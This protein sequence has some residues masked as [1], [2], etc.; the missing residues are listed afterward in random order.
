MSSHNTNSGITMSSLDGLNKQPSS[1]SNS[2][3]QQHQQAHQ[4]HSYQNSVLPLT[5]DRLN[6]YSNGHYVNNNNTNNNNSPEMQKLSQQMTY[7]SGV[8]AAATPL[9]V[10]PQSTTIQPPVMPMTPQSAHS[11]SFHQS[12]QPQISQSRKC[13]Q[14]PP[15]PAPHMDPN[16]FAAANGYTGYPTDLKGEF[17]Y[18]PSIAAGCLPPQPPPPPPPT[19]GLY[20]AIHAHSQPLQNYPQNSGR[21]SVVG[22]PTTVNSWSLLGNP[23]AAAAASNIQGTGQPYAPTA[24]NNA[25]GLLPHP[26]VHQGGGYNNTQ[27]HFPTPITSNSVSN[28]A[29]Q[30]NY[31]GVI[32]GGRPNTATADR[33][34][35]LQQ[36]HRPPMNPQG[37]LYGPPPQAAAFGGASHHHQPTP[38]PPPMGHHPHHQLNPLGFFN[39]PTFQYP[40][41]PGVD[42]LCHQLIELIYVDGSKVECQ[43]ATNAVQMRSMSNC[44][45]CCKHPNELT[46]V[47]DE[48]TVS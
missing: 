43:Q 23:S 38:P 28:Y 22:Y 4:I 47:A 32:G 35:S 6:I 12:L 3:R 37:G 14:M 30:S 17:N 2:P 39:N 29:N 16:T 25:G 8:G 10:H 20:S 46:V 48:I 36:H 11:R 15:Q 7:V 5:S 21:P 40:T 27:C 41:R 31:V 44:L 33:Q 1:I 26:V 34:R 13:R 19:A 9:Y 24:G 45:R 18:P 42:N